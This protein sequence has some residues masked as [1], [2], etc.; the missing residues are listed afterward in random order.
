MI[1]WIPNRTLNEVGIPL[2]QA[3]AAVSFFFSD[4]SYSPKKDDE[5]ILKYLRNLLNY[6]MAEGL[7]MNDLIIAFNK[8][9]HRNIVD[10]TSSSFI[11][12][13]TSIQTSNTNAY[14]ATPSIIS[15]LYNPREAGK[16]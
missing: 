16:I 9:Y 3:E 10:K 1:I 4:G 8:L 6:T 11:K 7:S 12:Y 13:N 14:E 5:T 15:L 2:A